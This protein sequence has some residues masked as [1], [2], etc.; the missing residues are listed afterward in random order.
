MK[1]SRFK[2]NQLTI[3]DYNAM[4][5]TYNFSKALAVAAGLLFHVLV[6]Q[7]QTTSQN[8]VRTRVP[9]LKIPTVTKLDALTPTKDSVQTTIAYVDGLGRPQQ[10][11][12]QKAS[13]AGNDIV[14]AYSY[15]GYD[16]EDKKYLPYSSASTA[17]GS[18]RADALSANAGVFS[19]YNPSGNATVDSKQTNAIVLTPNPYGQTGFEASPIGRTVEQG[20][21]GVS[22][23]ITG[24]LGEASSN[25]SQRVLYTTNNQTVFTTTNITANDGSRQVALYT[26]RINANGSRSLL[27]TANTAMYG[28]G[29]LDVTIGRDENWMPADKCFGS[30]ETYNDKQGN[31]V[32]KRT[33]NIKGSTA[34]MLST[35]YVYDERNL[36]SFVM[37]PGA[38]P[39]TVGVAISQTVLD[40]KCY[41]YRYDGRGRLTQ[42]KVPGKGWEFMIYNKLDQLIATQDSLQRMKASQEWTITKYDTFGRAVISG[43]WQ[44]GSSGTDNHVAVQALADAVSTYWEVPVTTGSTGYSGNAWPTTYTTTLSATYYD[45][46]NTANI[47]GFPTTYVTTGNSTHTTGLVTASKVLVLNTTGDYLWSVNY[48]DGEG[49]MVRTFVQH[50]LSGSSALSQYN[51][52]DL[53]TTYNFVQ[54]PLAVTRKH[55]NSNAGTSAVIKLTSA[56]AYTYDH[57]GRKLKL[58]N[59]LTDGTGAAQTPTVVYQNAYNEIGQLKQKGLHSINGTNFLQNVNYRYNARG[60]LSNINNGGL[61]N[62]TYTSTDLNDQFGMDI[63]YDDAA[64][65]QYNG[66]I[67]S[68]KSLTGI[69]SGNSYPALT[70]NYAYDKINRLTDAI[71]TTSATNDGFYS[72]NLTYD[73][74][75]NILT[76]KRYEK[77]G[78]T[79]LAIDNLNYVYTAA[80]GN[81]VDRIDDSGT[82]AGFSNAVSQAA[83]YTYDANGNQLIDL[84]KGLTQQ[85]N[86]LN[87]PQTAVKGGTSVAYIYDATGRKLRKLSTTAGITNVIEYI[88]G[89]QYEYSGS[90]PAIAFIQT[91]EGRARKS[92]TV[93][94]YEYDLKD[95]L[96]NTRVTTTW[97]GTDA[98]QMT[99]YNVQK[100]DY[101]ASGYVIQSTAYSIF[102][103][104]EYLYNH[105]ELQEETGLYDYGA[106]QYDPII[107]RWTSVDPLAEKMRRFSPYNYGDDNPIRNI[108]PDG[109]ETVT[110]SGAVSIS[111]GVVSGSTDFSHHQDN[112]DGKKGGANP[113]EAKSDGG[114]ASKG[115]NPAPASQTAKQVKYP[116]GLLQAVAIAYAESAGDF[117]IVGVQG[118]ASSIKNRIN[119]SGTSLDD[120]NWA[121]HTS[122]GGNDAISGGSVVGNYNVVSGKGPGGKEYMKVMNFKGGMAG[123]AKGHNKALH[124]AIDAFSKEYWSKDYSNPQH[125]ADG[126][127][128]YYWIATGSLNSAASQYDKATMVITL[129][130]NGTTFFRPKN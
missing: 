32:L 20:S 56:D 75:G 34:Q 91:E 54:Q 117:D 102:P 125:F 53:T 70:Y 130:V 47:P 111:G 1:R 92:S 129:E 23:K 63:K 11:V 17:Y 27:R 58:T 124:A 36:L 18:Y 25:H 37:P 28:S 59:T 71:S 62:D 52:D 100:N 86:M 116:V 88:G 76:L 126:G 82:T 9:R 95:H 64:A 16:R 10:T 97:N 96:G 43:I 50:Y 51:Y 99:P 89:I 85:Y 35:Y 60:W 83:E 84:N 112:Q 81:K 12:M 57:M 41:Q 79:A 101:Y 93:Y 24:T 22:W 30:T 4:R 45:N 123:I 7:A 13:P 14:Q 48:Y 42:K 105:K 3:N 103:K 109:M 40:T 114:Q 49:K 108:D 72:E 5:S 39:D 68:I 29:Q 73:P 80:G 69:I 31:V 46:Y 90:S 15:D 65:P 2:P 115:T 74:M 67:G 118:I 121:L 21:P 122:Y 87:L 94:K 33:Y 55:Y 66:N 44:N 61:T 98:T 77:S 119:A 104:N 8:Y 128:Y 38:S 107:G 120:P 127:R 106:R 26:A 6:T 110:F 19:F 78:T 113:P